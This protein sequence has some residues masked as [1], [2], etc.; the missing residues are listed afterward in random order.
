MLARISGR[1]LKTE[2]AQGLY[3]VEILVVGL[4]SSLPTIFAKKMRRDPLNF[5]VIWSA[6][7]WGNASAAKRREQLRTPRSGVSSFAVRSERA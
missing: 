6:S 1:Y 7:E 4:Y 2:P 3:G 5:T